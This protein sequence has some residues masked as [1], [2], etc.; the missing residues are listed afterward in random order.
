MRPRLQTFQISTRK[1]G[2]AG[3]VWER[4][5]KMYVWVLGLHRSMRVRAHG[6]MFSRIGQSYTQIL[7]IWVVLGRRW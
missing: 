1:S 2:K 6:S 3:R 5:A 4:A 7:V